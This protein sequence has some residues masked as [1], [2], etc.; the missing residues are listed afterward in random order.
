MDPLKKCLDKKYPG[1]S[2]SKPSSTGNYSLAR[3]NKS[4]RKTF[5]QIFKNKISRL[6]AEVKEAH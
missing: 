2:E 5:K 4:L 1:I 6:D 3:S